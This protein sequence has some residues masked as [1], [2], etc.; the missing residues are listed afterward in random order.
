[1]VGD[2]DIYAFHFHLHR[3]YPL[4]NFIMKF[5]FKLNIKISLKYHK[6]L[7]FIE[8]NNPIKVPQTKGYHNQEKNQENI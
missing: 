8:K 5:S 3:H 1:M 6:Y 4:I 2:G 7:F